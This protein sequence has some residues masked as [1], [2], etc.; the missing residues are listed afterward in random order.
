M[1]EILNNDEILKEYSLDKMIRYNHRTMLQDESVA[2][3]SFFVSLFVLKIYTKLGEFKDKQWF[4]RESLI[5]AALHDTPEAYT[6]DIPHDVKKNYPKMKEILVN[7]EE[8]YYNEHWENYSH[9]L[10]KPSDLS[11]N[12]IKLADAYSVRQF[13]LSEKKLGNSSS[14]VEEILEESLLRIKQRT[15]KI[16]KIILNIKGDY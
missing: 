14:D 5:L 7:I 15:E 13:A 1:L 4:E 6:S 12:I 3:H 11:H 8:D 9:Y 10:N 2:S 16:N